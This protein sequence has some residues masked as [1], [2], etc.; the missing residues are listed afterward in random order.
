M[1]WRGPPDDCVGFVYLIH[2]SG[3]TQQGHQ[4]YLGWSG[5]VYQRFARHKSGRGATETRKAVTEGLRLTLAQTW[6]GT[7]A[8]ERRIKAERRRVGR[9]FASLCPF[10]EVED[11][12]ADDLVCG[13]GPPTLRVLRPPAEDAPPDDMTSASAS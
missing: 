3:R 2:F 10:C 5:D 13:M 12:R 11:E 9:G 1:A 7:P 6:R 4:H 8:D